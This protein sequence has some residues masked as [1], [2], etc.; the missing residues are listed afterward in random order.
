MH[1]QT[2]NWGLVLDL[3]GGKIHSLH[4]KEEKV[5]GT[6]NRIDGKGGN[7]HLCLPNFGNEGSELGLPFHG[8]ARNVLWSVKQKRRY[9]IVIS[10]DIPQTPLYLASLH[11]EQSFT[12]QDAF[13]HEVKV[14]NTGKKAVPLNIGCHYYWNTP[15]GWNKI[16]INGEDVSEKI[17]VN[18][19]QTLLKENTF[20]FPHTSYRI[21]QTGFSDVVLWTGFIVKENKKKFD[22]GYCCIEPVRGGES[23]FGSPESLLSP[24]EEVSTSFQIDQIV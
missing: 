13:V 23:F 20:Q 19:S 9:S 1:L 12:L 17:G 22:E 21:T 16:K 24:G 10:C 18:G 5:L 2:T 8:P 15:Q 6:Y 11:V 14:I 3:K 7:T 4:H